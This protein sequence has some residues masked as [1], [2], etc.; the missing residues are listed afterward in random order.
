M[1]N[2]E[3]NLQPPQKGERPRAEWGRAVVDSINAGRVSGGRGV[4]VSQDPTGTVFKLKRTWPQ[5][6]DEEPPMPFDVLV[7]AVADVP[8]AH[9]WIPLDRTM[10]VS[11]NGLPAAFA[12]SG[13]LA[14]LPVAD[15]WAELSHGDVT[16]GTWIVWIRIYDD[17]GDYSYDINITAAD[18]SGIDDLPAMAAG[19]ESETLARRNATP[20]VLAVIEGGN[21]QQRRRG[22]VQTYYAHPDIEGDG[23]VASLDWREASQRM[24]IRNFSDMTD[25][26]GGPP[27]MS[28][29]DYPNFQVVCRQHFANA[30]TRVEYI[31]MGDL[32][33]ALVNTLTEVYEDPSPWQDAWDDYI[34]DRIQNIYGGGDADTITYIYNILDNRYWL[35]GGTA[36]DCYGDEIG[37]G[38]AEGA[39]I[40]LANLWLV[41][42]NGTASLNWE[43]MEI[44][45]GTG[46]DSILWHARQLWDGL[47]AP[48]MSL[49]WAARK[50]WD[51]QVGQ[52]EAVNWGDRLLYDSAGDEAADWGDRQLMSPAIALPTVDWGFGFLLTTA[53]GLA[54]KVTAS[55][56]TGELFD[57]AG[58]GQHTPNMAT[59][60]W[61]ARQLDGAWA[62]NSGGS[63]ATPSLILSGTTVTGVATVAVVT[64]VDFGT[65]T[66]TTQNVKVL[67]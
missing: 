46:D 52:V 9:V 25:V 4:L 6:R 48:S 1:S 34:G 24:E 14:A 38:V 61:I 58:W 54:D 39:I 21:V 53:G 41:K 33:E 57:P 17:A 11:R 13:A 16:A 8:T 62:V 29:G 12:P 47:A 31:A 37:N 3:H 36:A 30:S 66:V 42:T 60:N 27:S 7:E 28:D 67:T 43:S 10:L 32:A 15:G 18:G 65:Q 5:V 63:L 56:M 59:L 20:V 55:W 35:K 2:M 40:D 44:Y 45:D 49:D 19:V 22:H 26:L 50:L 51:G 64:A 23:G